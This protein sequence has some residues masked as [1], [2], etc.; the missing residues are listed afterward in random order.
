MTETERNSRRTFLKSTG[1]LVAIG[2]TTS[3][4]GCSSVTGEG[5]DGGGGG[6][7]INGEVK[8]GEG[9]KNSIEVVEHSDIV[10]SSSGTKHVGVYLELANNSEKD[11]TVNVLAEFYKDG[12]M[13]GDDDGQG[14]ER[15][16]TDQNAKLRYGIQGTRDDV[17]RYKV[18]IESAY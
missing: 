5:G 18:T 8:L 12:E 10:D 15:I 14:S 16:P 9:V 4:A 2:L 13:T 1:G 7:E 17:D 6:S 11:V 3:L